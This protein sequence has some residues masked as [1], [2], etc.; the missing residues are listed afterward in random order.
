[1]GWKDRGEDSLLHTPMPVT[2]ASGK[3][4]AIAAASPHDSTSP[5]QVHVHEPSTSAQVGSDE[6]ANNDLELQGYRLID[7]QALS[8]TLTQIA[9]CSQCGSSLTLTE[10]LSCRRGLVS[11]LS[12]QCRNTGCGATVHVTDTYSSN[13]K[14]LNRS[15]VLGMR[16]IGRGR[17]GLETFCAMMVM[18]PPVTPASY[19]EHCSIVQEESEV[20]ATA[21]Q[22][23]ASAYLH[24][25]HGVPQ[26][27]VLDVTVTC[28]GTW[29][30]RG[31]TALYGVVVVASWDS[32]QVLDCEIL[33]KYCPDCGAHE[34]MDKQT[35]EYKEWWERH[36]D[37][38]S[39]NYTGSSPAMEAAG[40]LRIWQRSVE[41]LKL[42]YATM[43]SDGD[44]KTIKHLNDNKPY[45]D[46]VVEKNECVGHVQKRLGTQLRTLKKSGKRDG[47][48][49]PVRFGG[50]GRLT[51]KVIDQLQIFYGGAIRGHSND[52]DGMERAIWAI[53]YHSVS[54]DDNPQHQYCPQGVDSWCKYLQAAAQS[55]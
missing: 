1:M 3:K 10:E 55:L 2:T 41:K 15:S 27:S 18:L 31:F 8:S 6:E 46:V 37:V 32:G 49:K 47:N 5:L 9:K 13:A 52:L 11:R 22:N 53:F 29:S 21:S 42:R 25:L 30:K 26:S 14:C 43:I 36:K 23:R 19:S 7:C 40:A 39:V 20:V 35:N 54:T 24:E 51:D 16:M 34:R 38:C 50:R 4:L 12:I 48:G 28:D 33:T 17:S 44:S 45:G